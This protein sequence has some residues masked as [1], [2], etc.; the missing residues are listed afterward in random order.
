MTSAVCRMG[1]NST[2]QPSSSDKAEGTPV[3]VMSPRGVMPKSHLGTSRGFCFGRAYGLP[4][5]APRRIGGRSTVK[6][7]S[8]TIVRVV[9][10]QGIIFRCDFSYLRMADDEMCFDDTDTKNA[11]DRFW[12]TYEKIFP[13]HSLPQRLFFAETVFEA[14]RVAWELRSSLYVRVDESTEIGAIHFRIGSALTVLPHRLGNLLLKSHVMQIGSE[15][16]TDDSESLE[17]ALVFSLNYE[18]M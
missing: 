5:D 7:F 18:T 12:E 15:K 6:P 1:K 10:M 4:P 17:L 13:D 3:T 14:I 11:C 8:E 9:I 16:S 2:P